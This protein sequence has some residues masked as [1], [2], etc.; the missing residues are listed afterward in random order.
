MD[1]LGERLSDLQE[2]LYAEAPGGGHRAVLLVLQ[3]MDTSGKD[4]MIAPRRRA[5]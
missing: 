2:R 4:G 3:G 1:A 5:R